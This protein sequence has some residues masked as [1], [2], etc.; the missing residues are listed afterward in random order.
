MLKW[1]WHRRSKWRRHFEDCDVVLPIHTYRLYTDCE[2][3][4]V[5][6]HSFREWKSI[7]LYKYHL[8]LLSN[9]SHSVLLEP[10]PFILPLRFVPSM[11]NFWIY[12]WMQL[13]FLICR[14][15]C[16]H[17]MM[18]W[19]L[20]SVIISLHPPR[21]GL[22]KDREKE[23]KKKQGNYWSSYH[24]SFSYRRF[25]TYY[26]RACTVQA[27]S[28]ESDMSRCLSSSISRQ[29]INRKMNGLFFLSNIYDLIDDKENLFNL[30]RRAIWL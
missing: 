13:S 24:F 2:R 18:K 20:A 8:I 23:R 7:I 16:I 28:F 1:Y 9:S 26:V 5:H 10:N 14:G 30:K 15:P 19:L 25:R 4:L 11:W 22:R 6:A 17:W 29:L 27:G 21:L 3:C 12:S